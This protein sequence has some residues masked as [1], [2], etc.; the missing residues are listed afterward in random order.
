MHSSNLVGHNGISCSQDS[1]SERLGNEG[2]NGLWPFYNAS[3]GPDVVI[4]CQ[5]L[6]INAGL[7]R[8]IL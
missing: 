8:Q 5:A 7:S 2:N 6:A 4:D 1:S 3:N